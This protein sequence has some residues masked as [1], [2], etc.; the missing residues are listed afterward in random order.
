[1][2]KTDYEHYKR[3]MNIETKKIGASMAIANAIHD[4]QVA[5]IQRC[6]QVGWEKGI[7]R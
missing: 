7:R 4:L 2:Q 5:G 3:I 6:L 1:M